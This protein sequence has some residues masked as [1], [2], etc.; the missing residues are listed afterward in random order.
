MGYPFDRTGPL[1]YI[2]LWFPTPA[3]PVQVAGQLVWPVCTVELAVTQLGARHAASFIRA[4]KLPN[5]TFQSR[6]IIYT[7]HSAPDH[8]LGIFQAKS[9]I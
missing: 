1:F 4:L 2:I 8:I 7:I 5:S 6:C 9:G 3:L